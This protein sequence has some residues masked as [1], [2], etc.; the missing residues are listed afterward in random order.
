[1]TK[2]YSLFFLS[3]KFSILSELNFTEFN[4]TVKILTEERTSLIFKFSTANHR[5]DKDG[6]SNSRL[7]RR[8]RE[9]EKHL[10]LSSLS[11]TEESGGKHSIVGAY[12]SKRNHI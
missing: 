6:P 12:K 3:N 4:H 7:A 1:M 8:A 2:I 5:H 9:R 11:L 10:I